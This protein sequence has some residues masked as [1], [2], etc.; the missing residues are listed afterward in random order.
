MNS[1]KYINGEGNYLADI[2]FVGEA[3]STEEVKQGKPFVGQSGKTLRSWIVEY[4]DQ[5]PLQF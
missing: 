1:V 5:D 2:I 3:P 4:L